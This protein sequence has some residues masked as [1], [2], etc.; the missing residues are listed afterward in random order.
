MAGNTAISD[1]NLGQATNLR[2][3]DLSHNSLITDKSLSLLTKL[4]I[5]DIDSAKNITVNALAPLTNLTTLFLSYFTKHDNHWKK[6]P[7]ALETDYSKCLELPHL[8]KLCYWANEDVPAFADEKQAAMH[9]IERL[10]SYNEKDE[11]KINTEEYQ[12]IKKWYELYVLIPNISGLH[13]GSYDIGLKLKSTYPLY[14]NNTPYPDHVLA[15][16]ETLKNIQNNPIDEDES[17]EIFTKELLVLRN[18]VADLLKILGRDIEI[19]WDH[20]LYS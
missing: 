7:D 19:D 5:L 9:I 3:L 15:Y 8:K 14:P 20:E 6:N 13:H 10:F 12:A 16:Y 2:T 4:T 18:K 17:Y 11:K 1:K